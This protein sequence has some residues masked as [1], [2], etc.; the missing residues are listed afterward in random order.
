LLCGRRSA[1]C[2]EGLFCRRIDD[3]AAG[4]DNRSAGTRFIVEVP[5]NFAYSG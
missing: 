3:L 1:L 2:G 4:D 5:V